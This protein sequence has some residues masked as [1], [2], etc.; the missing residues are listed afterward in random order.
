M[1]ST[2]EALLLSQVNFLL[3]PPQAL[4]IQATLQSIPNGAL[5][6]ITFD[7][8]VT[9]GYGGHSN[10][11]NNSRYTAQ[12]AGWYNIL[13]VV[14]FSANN[15]GTRTAEVFKNGAGFAYSQD[16]FANNGANAAVAITFVKVQLAVGDYVEL[17]GYQTSGGA[18]NTLVGGPQS[19]M[20]IDFRH[21]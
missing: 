7:S 5:T 11:T 14:A 12:V 9:D 13:G 1:A 10:V 3:N 8:S 16:W 17:N 6:P 21:L 15:T 18:L 2:F 19:A 4:V 20:Q